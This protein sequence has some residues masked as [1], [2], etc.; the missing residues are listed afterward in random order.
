MG[1]AMRPIMPWSWT[2]TWVCMF[3][4]Q[5]G[6]GFTPLMRAIEAGRFTVAQELLGLGSCGLET[7]V[8][9]EHVQSADVTAARC[10]LHGTTAGCND[11]GCLDVI[12]LL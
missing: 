2:S 9:C 11:M 12:D 10:T 1:C 5:D 3:A 7:Q 4:L 6:A 8:G